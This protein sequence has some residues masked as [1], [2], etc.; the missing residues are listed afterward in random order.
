M[1]LMKILEKHVILHAHIL[2]MNYKK[3]L[4]ISGLRKDLKRVKF[5]VFLK[6]KEKLIKKTLNNLFI[7]SILLILKTYQ[8]CNNYLLIFLDKV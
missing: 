8:L 5:T 4:N 1:N 2:A 6:K 7:V 3:E